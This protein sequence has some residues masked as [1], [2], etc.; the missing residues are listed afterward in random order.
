MSAS[1][2]VLTIIVQLLQCKNVSFSRKLKLTSV[3]WAKFLKIVD[4]EHLI[5]ILPTLTMI[6]NEVEGEVI[7]RYNNLRFVVRY[8]T[9]ALYTHVVLKI[10]I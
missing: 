1:T 7:R 9:Q 2:N 3:F 10:F 5:I 6:D 4:V 8:Y